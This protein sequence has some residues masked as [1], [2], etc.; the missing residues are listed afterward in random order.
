[1]SW[2]RFKRDKYRKS[3]DDFDHDVESR[4]IDL[5]SSVEGIVQSIKR[6]SYVPGAGEAGVGGRCKRLVKWLSMLRDVLA[7]DRSLSASRI[8]WLCD[9]G[10]DLVSGIGDNWD[11]DV[12]DKIVWLCNAIVFEANDYVRGK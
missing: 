9:V 1:L 2:N 6:D 7:D 8:R 4:G 5:K 10:L 12:W 3:R 11:F